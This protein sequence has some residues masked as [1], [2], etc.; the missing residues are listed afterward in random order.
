MTTLFSYILGYD[1]AL[2]KKQTHASRQKVATSALLLMLPVAVWLIAGYLLM[3]E[4]TDLSQGAAVGMGI[5]CAVIIFLIDRS[6]ITMPKTGRFKWFGR[7]RLIFAVISALLGSMV[8]DL[9]FFQTDIEN[10]QRRM[11]EQMR[12]RETQK[13]LAKDRADYAKYE[14]DIADARLELQERERDFVAEMD[15][16]GGGG[17]G[18]GR[19]ARQKEKLRNEAKNRLRA[20]EAEYEDFKAEN[21]QRAQASATVLADKTNTGVMERF[22]DFHVF[23]LSSKKNIGFYLLFLFILLFMETIPL[24]MKWLTPPSSFERWL[25]A[26]DRLQEEE[27]AAAARRRERMIRA[28]AELGA[29][30]VNDIL[31]KAG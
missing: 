18:Y 3:V 27:I 8:I 22:N 23:V 29:D 11:S 12:E 15:G 16:R 7:A 10:H 20:L 21:Y 2:V 28:R 24:M 13:I 17:V 19:I 6:F 26:Q 4:F 25:V 1:P 5:A 9:F 31:R 30:N 14:A